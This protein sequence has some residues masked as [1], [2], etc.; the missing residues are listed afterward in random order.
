MQKVIQMKCSNLLIFCQVLKVI[1]HRALIFPQQLISFILP[2][3]ACLNFLL[4]SIFVK[5]NSEVPGIMIYEELQFKQS[6]VTER[7]PTERAFNML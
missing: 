5:T 3:L 4:F 7:E 1:S 2:T 6:E